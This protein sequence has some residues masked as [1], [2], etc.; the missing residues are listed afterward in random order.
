[1]RDYRSPVQRAADAELQRV[2]DGSLNTLVCHAEKYGRG[3]IHFAC[4]KT[5]V[6]VG[7]TFERRSR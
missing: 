3:W 7:V 6:E 5:I 4:G 1:V 2:V